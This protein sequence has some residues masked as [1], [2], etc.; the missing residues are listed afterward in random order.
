M[1]TVNEKIKPTNK[2]NKKA[3]LICYHCGT[4][5][6]NDHIS[7]EEKLFCCE[8][9]KLVYEI[10]NNNGLCDYYKLQSHPGLSQIKPL[11]SDKYAYLDNEQICEKLYKFSDGK[12]AIVTLYIPGV[13]CSSCMWLLEHMHRLTPGI[14]ESRLHFSTK[15]LTIHFSTPEISLRK[16]VELLTTIGYEPHISL[17]D[18]KEEVFSKTGKRKIYKLGVAG[19]CFGNIMMMSFPEYFF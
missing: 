8:G 3:S 15:E 13:H 4:A 16:I 19:F 14:T 17:Q 1:L 9:C 11:R 12:H 18:G 7:L 2:S 6:A 10:L 5:C